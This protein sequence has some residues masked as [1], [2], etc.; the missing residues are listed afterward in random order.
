MLR[1]TYHM[2]WEDYLIP[3]DFLES[4]PPPNPEPWMMPPENPTPWSPSVLLIDGNHTERG[5]Y[6]D[7]LRRC[8]PDS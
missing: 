4:A 7:G 5:F 1:A 2:A 8:S 6:T 3:T